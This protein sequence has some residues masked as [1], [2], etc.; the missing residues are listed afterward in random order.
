MEI[1]GIKINNLDI[2]NVYIPPNSSCDANYKASIAPL[3]RSTDT[4]ILGDLNAHDALW[5][6]SLSDDRGRD[7]ADEIGNSDFGTLN[8][9]N[10]TRLPSNGP[11]SSPDVSI[12]SQSILPYA[13]WEVKTSLGSDHLPILIKLQ[14]DIK[15]TTSD[16]RTF[17]NFRKANW[18][19][20]KN[21]TEDDFSQLPPPTD[22]YTGEQT[23]RKT[24]L[25]AAKR[26]IPAGRIKTVIPEVPTSTANKIKERDEIR[27]QDPL[28]PRIAQLNREIEKEIQHHK[29]EK[30]RETVE[31]KKAD[32]TKLFKLLKHLNGGTQ[33]STN[34]AIKFKGK[35]ITTPKKIA[36]RFNNQYSSVI[37]HVSTK[38]ARTVTK[39]IKKNK[40]ADSDL[41]TT[42]KT[43]TAIKKAKASKALGPDKLS[44]LHLKNLGDAG[45]QYLTDLFNLSIQTGQIPA[46]WKTSTIIPLLKPGKP[47]EES[48]SYRPVSLLCPSIKI[49]ERVLLPTLT[50]HLPVPDIQHGFRSQH[51]T[52]TALHS[53]TEAIAGGFNEKKPANRTLLVQID[54]SKAF[55]M[56]SHEKLLKDLN[57][58]SLPDGIKRWFNSYLHGR[59]SRVNFRNTT[60]AARN[61][62]TGVP[63]GAVSSPI[64]FNFYLSNLP[65]IP[66]GITLIQYADDISIYIQGTNV[67]AL[68]EKVNT[69]MSD[70]ADFLEERNLVVSPEKST[71]TW[72]T[73]ASSEANVLPKITIKGKAVKL[74]KTPKLL[75]V[76]YDTM[77]C[78]GP[79]IRETVSKAKKKLNL[80]KS[81]AGSSWGCHKETIL[82]TYKSIVRSVLEYASPV[83][84]PVIKDC[85]WTRLQSIQSQALRIATGCLSMSA[86]EHLHSETLV[87][88]I[89]EH[90]QMIGKQYLASCHLPGHPGQRIIHNPPKPRRMKDT[91]TT[92]HNTEVNNLLPRTPT[93][94]DYKKAIKQ[95]H[96]QEV[97]KT[98]NARPPNKVLN[99]LPPDINPEEKSLSRR[100]RSELARLRSGYS[101]RL[102]NYLARI[103]PE[104]QDICPLCNATPHNTAHL[105]S[106]DQNPTDLQVLDLWTRPCLAAD[107]LNLD[108][109]DDE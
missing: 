99:Q 35:Y 72:F 71:V 94:D 19:D 17:I 83:W 31:N 30:W 18:E 66:D 84:S 96:T 69:F 65:P 73:P 55:D 23:F 21:Q 42:D 3:L 47:A 32:T 93:K 46:I 45:L 109:N 75:G 61:V 50:E 98:L 102:N 63:Q 8:D 48:T 91:I 28:S 74:E 12:A 15:P 78:F 39:D 34:E 60:S 9:D 101:R 103:D 13:T 20:F 1:L 52:V 89:R 14:S 80:L 97:R 58:T 44:T 100:A 68:S 24:V 104:I 54:L 22:V 57:R 81:L 29:R 49:L 37:R 36:D 87:M 107:F 40:A 59:Q 82:L 11:Q 88:P 7:I 16:K 77:F 51:S 106:C 41:I 105:F 33:A 2:L 53:F 70:M 79:H 86:I 10:P 76:T 25:K 38:T 56:V 67:D 5:H 6:S 92:L 95:I 85:H 108:D 26:T 43:R 62:R 64:L 27:S 4:L 90:C